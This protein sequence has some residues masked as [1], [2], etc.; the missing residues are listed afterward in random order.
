MGI[1]PTRA[2]KIFYCYAHRDKLLIDKLDNHLSGLKRQGYITSWHD[3]EI[4]PGKEWERE[5]ITQLKLAHIILL[6]VSPDFMASKY[7]Y[8]IEMKYALE[9]HKAGFARVIPI[10]LRPVDW[11]DEPFCHLQMLPTNAKPVT[12]WRDR[13]DAFEDI[14]KGIRK[15][16]EELAPHVNKAEKDQE[17]E[18]ARQIIEWALEEQLIGIVILSSALHEAEKRILLPFTSGQYELLCPDE[19]GK[20]QP[21]TLATLREPASTTTTLLA[22]ITFSLLC[23]NKPSYWVT[24]DD[25]LDIIEFIKHSPFYIPSEKWPFT[26]EQ[27]QAAWGKENAE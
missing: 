11:R 3:H 2:L 27:I 15:V 5:I 12:S 6:L 9:R 24:P 18:G 23:G 4:S 16:V 13:N 25:L 26:K 22:T 14:A 1:K 10:L 7:C 17:E 20:L 8:G 19:N 21:C